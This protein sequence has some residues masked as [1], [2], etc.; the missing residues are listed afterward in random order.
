MRLLWKQRRCFSFC[1]LKKSCT[2]QNTWYHKN[3]LTV[4]QTD[5]HP[6]CNGYLQCTGKT[7]LKILFSSLYS[8]LPGV[9][10]SYFLIVPTPAGLY[11][12]G[13]RVLLTT[14]QAHHAGYNSTKELGL[15]WT[16]AYNSLCI[17]G[18]RSKAFRVWCGLSFVYV[19][20]W[21][22]KRGI[23]QHMP[24]CLEQGTVT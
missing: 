19:A 20:L 10:W 23:I 5:W 3:L 9:S 18:I 13:F 8:V 17:D 6:D 1:T 2:V 4:K 21:L 7:C 16:F 11:G 14:G 22:A 12:P 15:C 24:H